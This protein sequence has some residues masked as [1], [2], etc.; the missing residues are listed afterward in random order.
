MS[1]MIV[2]LFSLKNVWLYF[3]LSIVLYF[4][5]QDVLNLNVKVLNPFLGYSFVGF[6]VFLWNVKGHCDL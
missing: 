5:W 2:N 4:L 3:E 6:I 1:A